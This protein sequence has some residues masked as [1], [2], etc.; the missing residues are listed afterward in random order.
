MHKDQ[1]SNHIFMIEP[2]E[3]FSNP[4]TAGS[5]HYQKDDD[6][7]RD[8]ILKLAINEFRNFRDTLVNHAFTSQPL[9]VIRD[10]QIIFFQIGLPHSQIKQCKFFQ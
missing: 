2:Q 5:N 9:K 8:Q 6:I 1:S 3:F 10:V 7:S 4:Q